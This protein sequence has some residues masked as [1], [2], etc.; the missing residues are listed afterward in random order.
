MPRL[1]AN[2]SLLFTE[3]DFL[4]RFKAAADAGF[5]GVEYL[6]P[7]DYPPQQLQELL[8]ENGLTQVLFN[9]PPGDWDAGERGIACHPL[10]REEFREGLEEAIT[11]ARA[12]DCRRVHCLAGCLPEGVDTA[13]ARSTL[14]A[15]LAEAAPRFGQAGVTLLLE[16]INTRD[17]PGFLVHRSADALA[18]LDEAGADNLA[19]QYDVYHMQVMEG[20]LARTMEANLARIGHIQIADNPGRHEPGTGEIHYPYLLDRLDEWGYRGWVGCEYRPSG[21]TAASLAWAADYLDR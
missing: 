6:F 9:L 21:D 13:E 12:L 17:I 1:A 20:D 8:V 2:L 19:L 5:R 10:R 16:A 3:Y 18:I 15:S 14:V 4:D 11:Y 7:Y